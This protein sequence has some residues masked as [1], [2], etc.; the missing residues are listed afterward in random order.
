MKTALIVVSVIFVAI[1]AFS[2]GV[3]YGKTKERAK[4]ESTVAQPTQTTSATQ[5][6]SPSA[7][8]TATSTATALTNASVKV[9]NPTSGQKI[10][11]PLSV[12]G[13][14]KGTWYSEGE[15]PVT[16]LD[17]NGAE[18]AKANATAQGEWMTEN[19]VSF[20]ATL[21]FTTPMSP[22]GT[23]ILKNSDPSG[24]N[25]QEVKIPVQF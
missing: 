16:L 20:K 15:F 18:I 19:F 25:P 1:A 11:S 8:S 2:G 4:K 13:E 23:L 6:T 24:K 10:T 17:G 7:T 14:A 3:Y 21:E 5:T 22:T 12:T 9:T